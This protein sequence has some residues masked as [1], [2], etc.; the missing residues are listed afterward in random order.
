M[1]S[2]PFPSMKSNSVYFVDGSLPDLAALLA[3]LPAGAEVHLLTP[4][5]DGMQLLA[6]TLQGR[7]GMDAIHLLTHGSAGSLSLGSTVLTS[8][9]L[10]YYSAQWATVQAALSE[11]GDFLIYGCNVAEGDVGATFIHQ[12]SS[13][14]GAHSGTS[15]S[16]VFIGGNYIKLGISAV[17]FFGTNASKPAGFIGTSA[18][19]VSGAMQPGQVL[20]AN[21][22]SIA[23]ADVVAPGATNNQ[24]PSLTGDGAF[25]ATALF[26]TVAVT[27]VESGQTI[28]TLTLSVSG[29]QNGALEKLT[30]DGAL[31]ELSTAITASI[32]GGT[33]GGMNY[34]IA[35][36]GNSPDTAT[37]T[38]THTGLTPAQTKTLIE[39][40]AL[41]SDTTAGL[42]VVTLESLQ[43][44]GGSS[45]ATGL[46]CL[47]ATVNVDTTLPGSNHAPTA[48]GDLGA[49]VAEGALVARTT[50]D[51][52]GTD[53]EH[54]GGLK[55]QLALAPAHGTLFRDVNDNGEMDS[56]EALDATSKL[57][58]ADVAA[59]RIKY[60]HDGSENTTD[61]F[62][63]N[64]SDGLA[65]SDAEPQKAIRQQPSRSPSPRWTMP[66][67]S[68]P[69][70]WAPAPRPLAPTPHPWAP[71]LLRWCLPKG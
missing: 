48:T 20:T 66:P 43:Y 50:A 6:D 28:K 39:D 24:A 8:A 41:S 59:G 70:P 64:L 15:G 55:V 27:T 19:V 30:V 29:L 7:T 4:G 51:L 5:Q 46:V 3:G 52:A 34:A 49:M 61:S 54:A 32:T 63:F 18:P 22:S 23:D 58:L 57:A 17:G 13:L 69:R 44:S 53:T 10:A 2:A 42:R 60:L 65:L 40:L 38:L 33:L 35:M 25:P 21:V 56:G 9:N 45:T 68:A 71:A 16:E 31:I 62:T 36:A 14:T 26:S 1:S 47:S 67:P 12:L 37:V 11:Q